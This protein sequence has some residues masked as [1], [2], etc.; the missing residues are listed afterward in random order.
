MKVKEKK[1]KDEEVEKD[2]GI[3][4]PLKRPMLIIGPIGRPMSGL[5]R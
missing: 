2:R 3:N 5:A 1:I 4:I